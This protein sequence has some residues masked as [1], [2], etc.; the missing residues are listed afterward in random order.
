MS[1]GLMIGEST[2]D[3]A[4][5]TAT[6]IMEGPDMTGTVVKSK[7]VVEYKAD[8]TRVMSMYMKGP[9]G[10]EALTMRISYSKK[11]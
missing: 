9:D 6:G 4:T 2:F 3:Q 5:K 7:S 1:Q 11:K 8:G 10:K